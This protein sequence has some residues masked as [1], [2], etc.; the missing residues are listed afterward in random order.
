MRS[1][2]GFVRFAWKQVF[3]GPSAG[4]W[5]AS[6]SVVTATQA[7]PAA[8]QDIYTCIDARGRKL[9]SDRPIA[10]CSDREQ[11][12]LNASGTL[13]ARLTPTPTALERLAIEA[14]NKAEQQEQA[15]INEEKRRD[16]ALLI[17]YPN[18]AVHDKERTQAL[19]QIGVVR[20]AAARRV[21]E[22]LG[23]RTAINQEMEFYRKDPNKAPPSIRRQVDE[24][25]QSLAVQG[26]FIADQ[27]NE[28][29][30]VNARFDEEQ[31]R[32]NLLWAMQSGVA[33][34]AASKT[35]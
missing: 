13:K 21:D 5:L 10:E 6:L 31:M 11:K 2:R 8:T 32:L 26:R 34:A 12:L 33:P 3:S 16:R 1:W 15:R 7:Q 14:K 28:L 27:D 17:R 24:V 4:L 29:K 22:L 18:Q 25:A 9:T 35:R 19:A 20:Q 30:R 23:Q